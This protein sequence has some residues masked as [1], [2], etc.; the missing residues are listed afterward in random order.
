LKLQ[1]ENM[2]LKQVIKFTYKHIILLTYI[3]LVGQKISAQPKFYTAPVLCVATPLAKLSKNEVNFAKVQNNRLLGEISKYP[4]GGVRIMY[5]SKEKKKIYADIISMPV[6]FAVG[7]VHKTA[8]PGF[9]DEAYSNRG[10]AVAGSFWRLNINLASKILTSKMQPKD[11]FRS[12][13]IEWVYGFGIDIKS[14]EDFNAGTILFPGVNR[15]GEEF[16]LD[17]TAINFKRFGFYIPLA[18]N[19]NTIKNGKPGLSLSVFFNLGLTTRYQES[20]KYTTATYKKEMLFD[21]K[22]TNCGLL[23]SYPIEFLRKRKQ[24]S[25]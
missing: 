19:I 8:C 10:K 20:V 16:F 23:L 4:A 7:V 13:E 2:V 22:G 21:V 6:G 11:G 18:F 14:K 5:L 3:F 12:Y 9:E 24:K 17:D 1:A 15:C 25:K